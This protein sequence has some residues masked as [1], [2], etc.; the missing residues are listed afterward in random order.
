MVGRAVFD[1]AGIATVSVGT[2][3]KTVTPGFDLTSASQ[4]HCTLDSNQSGLSLQRV[5]KNTTA[6]TF[7]IT[8]SGTVATGKYATVA[9]IVLG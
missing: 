4:I 6:D 9:W 5:T 1:L 8:L 2:K 3:S 7:K